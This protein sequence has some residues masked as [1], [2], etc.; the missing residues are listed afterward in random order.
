MKIL[1]P[2]LQAAAQR[3]APAS[4]PNGRAG[5]CVRQSAT[6]HTEKISIGLRMAT[7]PP[8]STL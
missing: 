2:L 3:Y 1:L 7:Q 4:L 6:S 8:I 5:G